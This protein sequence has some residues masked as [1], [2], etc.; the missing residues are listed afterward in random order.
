MFEPYYQGILS[1]DVENLGAG[2]GLS[3]CKEIVELYGGTISVTSEVN[4]GT[5]VNFAINLN[6]NT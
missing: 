3:L 5:T 4:K 1:E 2:L 6:I